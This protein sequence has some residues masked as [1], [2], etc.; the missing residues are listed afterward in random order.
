[1]AGEA[2]VLC[3]LNEARVRKGEYDV[4]HYT[5]K[6][7]WASKPASLVFFLHCGAE[8]FEFFRRLFLSYPPTNATRDFPSLCHVGVTNGN[9]TYTWLAFKIPGLKGCIKLA[10]LELKS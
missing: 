2:E 1:M 6:G 9:H 8:L 3:F 5:V 4:P 7:P 10:E